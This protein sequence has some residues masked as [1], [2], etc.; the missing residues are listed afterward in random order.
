[1]KAGPASQEGP[2]QVQT[3]LTFKGFYIFQENLTPTE[4]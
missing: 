2:E 3:E 1:M 4:T